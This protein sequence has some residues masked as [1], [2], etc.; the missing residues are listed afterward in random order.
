MFAPL[1]LYSERRF[2]YCVNNTK[3][4]QLR[5]KAS[6]HH[7]FAFQSSEVSFE[8]NQVLKD[9]QSSSAN[10]LTL[11]ESHKFDNPTKI[12]TVRKMKFRH[13]FGLNSQRPQTASTSGLNSQASILNGEKYLKCEGEKADLEIC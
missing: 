12:K 2:N 9:P 5:D 7:M 4:H 6:A 8:R 1:L 13:L 3:R 11:A 10:Y